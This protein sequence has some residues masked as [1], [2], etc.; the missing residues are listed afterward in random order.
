VVSQWLDELDAYSALQ[1]R[2]DRADVVC[3]I[4]GAARAAILTMAGQYRSIT[5][6]QLAK[7][8]PDPESIKRFESLFLSAEQ[9]TPS[10]VEDALNSSLTAYAAANQALDAIAKLSDAIQRLECAPPIQPAIA[11]A[12]LSNYIQYNAS[13]AFAAS[14]KYQWDDAANTLT[15]GTG[16]A[17]GIAYV[18]AGAPTSGAGNGLY[19][20]ASNAVGTGAVA[21]GAMQLYGG[22][23][24]SSVASGNSNGGGFSMT[25]G[26]GYGATPS[27]GGF[28]IQ[29][30]STQ[31]NAGYGGNV[32]IYG[33]GDESVVGGNAGGVD[34][35]GGGT[36]NGTAGNASFRGGDVDSSGLGTGVAGSIFFNAGAD[37][38]GFGNDGEITFSTASATVTFSGTTGECTFTGGSGGTTVVMGASSSAGVPA[39]QIAG[40]SAGQ[41]ALRVNTSATTGG[42]TPTWTAPTNKPGAAAGTVTHWLPISIAGT[43]RYIP[44]WS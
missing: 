43:I 23:G 21:G 24:S 4:G 34:V 19:L 16:L 44:C 42:T 37:L 27:G 7:F 32:A 1:G 8:L 31:G 28:Y 12:G 22:D 38:A 9:T 25:G 2:F 18:K 10:L 17:G 39:L 15:L 6:D 40:Q 20:Q 26:I 14:I 36:V 3:T 35:R 41:P 11:A 33:G 29:G 13:G 5:R 30:G